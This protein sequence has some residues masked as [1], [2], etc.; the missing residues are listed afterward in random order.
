MK[1]SK[2]YTLEAPDGGWG[3][4]VCIGM[5][6][7][8]TSALAALPSFGLVFGDFLKSIGAETSAMAIITSA[9]FS[10]MSFAGLFSGSLF[11]RFGMRQVGVTGGILYFVG[12]GLQLFATSTFHL[13][14]AFSLIQG[15][16][17]GLMVPTCYTTFNHYFVKNR[18]MWMSFAQTLIGL[19]AMLYPIVMQKL[20][21][22][23][24]F[25]GCLLILTGLNAHAIL[26][27]LVM[28]PVEW[29]MRRVP[30]KEEEQELKELS[31]QP[32][33]PAVVVRVQPETP[34][35][36]PKEEPNFH[37]GDPVSRR[38]S[39][40]EE[41][42]LRVHSSRA[43]SITSLGNWSGPVVVSDASPQMMHSLQA[44]R[45]QSMVVGGAAGAAG[46]SVAQ[47]DAPKKGWVR[48]IVDFLDLTLLKKPIYVNIVL[49][50]T[51]ALYSDITFFT[52]QPVY[53][54]ELGY[55]RP[56]T[57]TIIAIGAAADLSS[58]IFLAITAVCIQVP[59]RY[60]YL[61]GAVLTVFARFVFNGITDFT[62]MAYITAVIGFLRTWLHV[63]LPL[64][65]ADYLSKERF[66]TGYGLFMFTQGNAMFLIGPIVGIIRDKTKDYILVFHILNGFMILC[67][68]PWVIEVLIVKF[69][70][71][72]KIER[73]NVD[74]EEVVTQGRSA[75]I[76]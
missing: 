57:A 29:H 51:F 12:T 42:M 25:R 48:T 41:H 36:V 26:G 6:L 45:R 20:M 5:A 22:W 53:L 75:M 21:H 11:Q 38:L 47:D 14:I 9:F 63:P 43:S 27:M 24:G 64:V 54:F 76:H 19:G 35:K 46:G 44:S 33:K 71:R 34:L 37:A 18:V 31:D 62:G 55:S 61:A 67:A 66:A 39:H 3:I 7:P 30:I 52:M 50:I 70:R 60:I 15:F 17:F 69:R 74:H 23:Y 72:S 56:D 49:G 68:V 2:T 65:F 1:K 59:S 32:V 16:A 10:S 58:R 73:N 4:L 13:L 28:H 8:F 40:A